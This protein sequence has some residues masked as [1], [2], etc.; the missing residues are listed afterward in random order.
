[1]TVNDCKTRQELKASKNPNPLHV[2]INEFRDCAEIFNKKKQLQKSPSK[3]ID[4]AE[5]TP[6]VFG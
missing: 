2:Y 3:K 6:F 1:M 4:P 5:N